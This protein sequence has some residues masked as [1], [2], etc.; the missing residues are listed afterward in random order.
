MS[1]EF[2]I[3]GLELLVNTGGAA[4][5]SAISPS[6]SVRARSSG[7]LQVWGVLPL[8]CMHSRPRVAWTRTC[9]APSE[10][11]TVNVT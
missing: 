4:G 8:L 7:K 9:R 10:A 5:I 2:G 11:M 3:S 6:T 1:S